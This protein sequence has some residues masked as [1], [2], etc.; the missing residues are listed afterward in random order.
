[1][2]SLDDIVLVSEEDF[3]GT[4]SSRH[5]LKASVKELAA[6]G[7]TFPIRYTSPFFRQLSMVAMLVFLKGTLSLHSKESEGIHFD[8]SQTYA[9]K[10]YVADKLSPDWVGR[11]LSPYFSVSPGTNNVSIGMESK[12]WLNRPLAR[13]LYCME[14][15]TPE[16]HST[17]KR[18]PPF[19]SDLV[20]LSQGL[21]AH[22]AK[23]AHRLLLDA[24][25]AFFNI[26]TNFYF[27]RDFDW[28]FFLPGRGDKATAALFRN[29]ILKLL[30]AAFQEVNF[31][32][33]G[34]P[35]KKWG[36]V[37]SAF[38]YESII[39]LRSPEV[40]KLLTN[41]GRVL[42]LHEVLSQR[43]LL[44]DFYLEHRN[45]SVH[46]PETRQVALLS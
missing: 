44:S 5:Q 11:K 3:A 46:L 36:G 20:S 2:A 12:S 14:V 39:G 24:C 29:N 42:D 4:Y 33:L 37:S 43:Q 17:V 45:S 1:M 30:R 28:E 23:L 27:S 15:P 25:E 16:E 7:I 21:E 31:I 8:Y 32:R 34:E 40:E 9:V 38:S 41:Y 22:E 19:I 13:I 35:R 6:S 26:K 18:L 10:I